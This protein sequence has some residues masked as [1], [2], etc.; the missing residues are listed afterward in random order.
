MMGTDDEIDCRSSKR[1][2]QK[3]VFLFLQGPNCSFFTEIADQLEQLGHR[4]LRVNLCF[5]DWLFWRRGGALNYRG[6]FRNWEVFLG[7][8]LDKE[9]VTEILMLG[10]Q[11]EYHRV[12][13]RL[14]NERVITVVV[15]DFGYL[16]PDW[17]TLEKN[18]MSRDSLLPR[19]S[20]IIT[21]VSEQL[22]PLDFTPK[23]EDNFK[24]MAF[25]EVISACGSWLFHF[26][27]PGYRKHHLDNPILFYCGVGFRLLRAAH[28]KKKADKVIDALVAGADGAPFFM[29]PM[30][31]EMDFQIR[32]YSP[33]PN[34]T[35][36]IRE[37][38]DS[39]SKNAPGNTHLVFKIHPMDPGLRNWSRIISDIAGHYGIKERVHFIDG[40][41][42]EQLLRFSSG[43]VTINS[44]VGVTAL[45]F[46][47]PLKVLGDAVYDIQGLVY[48]GE[49]DAFWGGKHTIDI[50][51]RDDFLKLLVRSIQLRG[52]YFSKEG[53][54][55]AVKEAVARLDQG[56]LNIPI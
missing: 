39:F 17:I 52:V 20:E 35:T 41:S 51:L 4:C 49:L 32:A 47:K 2:C 5:G 18:G 26:L 12:A 13:T 42:L 54:W 37:V 25:S 10:E 40:G 43:V 1:S 27:Y 19:D 53:R 16:R 50:R 55:N 30:Q 11:R 7:R 46:G 29:F 6:S 38:I 22:H 31:M 21:K 8:L 56:T 9:G 28:F 24:T 33:Y 48:Q 14:A 3:K 44:T 36:P 34:Q 45:Q 15:T 23:F